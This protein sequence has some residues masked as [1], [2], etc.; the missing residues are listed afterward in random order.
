MKRALVDTR[1]GTIIQ[2]VPAGGD[3]AVSPGYVWVECPAEAV[4]YDWRHDGQQCVGPP[5]AVLRARRHAQI[6][7]DRDRQ[8]REPVTAL[9]RTWQADPRSQELLAHAITL[10]QAG[11]PLPPIWRD[12]DNGAMPVTSIT[13]LL[14]IAGAIAANTRAAYEQSWARKGALAAATSPEQ[15][16]AA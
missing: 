10:A 7:R 16:S 9:G 13:D 11:H 6:E 15:I 4:A 12:A 2:V 8:C 1:D 14:A 5:L 3:F